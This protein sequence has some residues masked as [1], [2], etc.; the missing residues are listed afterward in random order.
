MVSTDWVTSQI[1]EVVPDA[2]V[3]VDVDENLDA[4]ADVDRDL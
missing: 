1:L 2:E 4:D 3:D